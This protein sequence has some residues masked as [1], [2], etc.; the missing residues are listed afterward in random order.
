L[1]AKA[2]RIDETSRNKRPEDALSES[3][4]KLAEADVFDAIG[5]EGFARLVQAFYRRIPT[6]ALLGP[7]Y[8]PKDFEGAER[9]LRGFLIFRFGGPPTYVE[10]RG[11]PRLRMR[12]A[13]FKITEA[14]RDRWVQIM[15][16]ALAEAGLPKAAERTLRTFFHEAATFLI[17][18]EPG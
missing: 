17:N 4:E 15:D 13:P 2:F 3:L 6:D 11:H 18:A 12:H 1:A 5:E 8:P 10:E 14:R 7:L 16:E 9:R